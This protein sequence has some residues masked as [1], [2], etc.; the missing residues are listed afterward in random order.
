MKLEDKK[1]K[2]RLKLKG[3]TAAFVDWANVYYWKDSLKWEIDLERLF[4]YLKSYKEIK[5]INFYF[6]TDVHPA[7]KEQIKQAQKIGFRVITKPVKYLPKTTESGEVVWIRKC[8]FDLEIGLDCFERLTKFDGFIFFSGDGDFATLYQ[9]LIQKKK[10]V[11]VIYMYGHLGK[12]VWKMKRGIFKASIVK[13]GADFFKKM[14]PRR[15]RGAQLNS[16]Y[17]KEKRLSR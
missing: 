1:E 10:Q 5:E 7:S 3:K 15:R 11:I 2:F 13:L 12:E 16:L 9:R 6:G 17:H 8:D 4:E 14:T